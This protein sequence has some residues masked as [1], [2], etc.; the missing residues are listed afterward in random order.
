MSALILKRK[1][2]LNRLNSY[3]HAYDMKPLYSIDSEYRTNIL[4]IVKKSILGTNFTF[5]YSKH[6][7]FITA[8]INFIILNT[9]FVIFPQLLYHSKDIENL[10]D[11]LIEQAEEMENSNN[12]QFLS[13]KIYSSDFI[14]RL[15]ISNLI[16]SFIL[17]AYTLNYRY[18][19]KIINKYMETYTQCSIES[20]N[21]KIKDKYNC[22]ISSDGNFKIEIK[23]SKNEKS[24]DS[25]YLLYK[26]KNYFFEYVIN[27]PNLKLASNYLYWKAFL[28][29][30]KE[31]VNRI[32]IISNEIE[33]KYKKKL[34]KFI[35]LLIAVLLF[36]PFLKYYSYKAN[37]DY[38]NYFS[39]L[40]LWLFFQVNI[41]Y[42]QSNEQIEKVSSLNDE[43]IK[44]GYFI[45]INSYM[46]SIFYLKEKYRNIES[47]GVLAELNKKFLKYYELI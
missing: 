27:F 24:S 16:D 6:S 21:S 19:E 11:D 20:E 4:R 14:F 9:C 10:I 3:V 43:Y 17:I 22:T 7:A 33:N 44:N 30:E 29:K 28:P 39:I 23:L 47:L 12:Y 5:W 40:I 2:H 37:L 13:K 8:I 26:N 31:I 46:I 1:D 25:N 41:H 34:F 36:I 18:K 15:C 32:L 35:L 42:N 45:S 38:L